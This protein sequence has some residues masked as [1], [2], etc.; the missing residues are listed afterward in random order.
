[1]CVDCGGG[2]VSKGSL[3]IFSPNDLPDEPILMDDLPP[4]VRTCAEA[5][6]VG[7]NLER[8]MRNARPTDGRYYYTIT[9]TDETEGLKEISHWFDG[10][11][12]FLKD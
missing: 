3:G 7:K 8:I 5:L 4:D 6:I 11:D 10:T 9:Y 1:M 12:D 2:A